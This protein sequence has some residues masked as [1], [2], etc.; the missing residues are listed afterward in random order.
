MSDPTAPLTWPYVFA[1]VGFAAA[2]IGLGAVAG[3]VARMRD[4][5]RRFREWQ[6]FEA[7]ER[8]TRTVDVDGAR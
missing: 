2:F 6:D 7:W 5:W 1:A 3:L 8:E 4:E